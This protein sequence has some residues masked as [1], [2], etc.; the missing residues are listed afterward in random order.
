MSDENISHGSSDG[1]SNQVKGNLMVTG[2]SILAASA[3][4]FAFMA[5]FS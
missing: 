5:G 1:K 4:V 2:V 3:L